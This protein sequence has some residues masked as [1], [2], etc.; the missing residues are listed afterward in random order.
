MQ[1][2]H[3]G[4]HRRSTSQCTAGEVHGTE[5]TCYAEICQSRVLSTTKTTRLEIAAQASKISNTRNAIA[6]PTKS[7]FKGQV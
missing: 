7:S 4:D 5:D 2:L 3:K 6:C 1:D